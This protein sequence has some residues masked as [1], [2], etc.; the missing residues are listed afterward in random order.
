MEWLSQFTVLEAIWQDIIVF[1]KPALFNLYFALVAIPFGFPFAVALAL[2]R[3]SP[4]WIIRRLCAL[5]IYAFRGSPLFIQFFMFYTLALTFNQDY[6][7]PW[8]IS[9]VVLNPLFLGVFVLVLNTAAYSAEIFAG[10]LRNVPK[11][12]V[13]AAYAMGMSQWQVFRVVKWPNMLR[14]AWPSYT[15]EVVFLF[16]ATA[17]VY[18]TLPVINQQQDLM[19]K[20]SELFNRDYN[21][22]L[23][24]SV[25]GLYFLVI[26]LLI[27]FVFN[28]VNHYLNR[29]LRAQRRSR[30]KFRPN[31][32]R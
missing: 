15:N 21:L 2:G 10:A 23:H 5:Y 26:S 28:Q 3:T 27:F 20:A 4:V 7:Q 31:Y 8:G 9:G 24:F 6:W 29:H 1:A 11:G 32:V 25:A 16:H 13:E 14:I 22:F 30:L 17:L 19:N 18:F 12:E